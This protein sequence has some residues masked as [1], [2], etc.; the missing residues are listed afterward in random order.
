VL[1]GSK[2]WQVVEVRPG[3]ADTRGVVLLAAADD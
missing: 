2:K 1:I 3:G